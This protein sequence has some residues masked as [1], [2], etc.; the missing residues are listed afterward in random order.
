MRAAEKSPD[1]SWQSAIALAVY[2]FLPL[3]VYFGLLAAYWILPFLRARLGPRLGKTLPLTGGARVVWFHAS[4]VGEVST[5]GPVVEEVRRRW[6]GTK[7]VVSTMTVGGQRRAGEILGSVDVFLLPLDFFPLIRNVVSILRP[8]T[9]IIG[10]TEIWPN[11]VLEARKQGSHIVLLNGRIS[12][13]S[14]PRYRLV[15]PLMRTLLRRFDY[16]LMRTRSDADRI[17]DLGADSAAVEVVGNTKFDILPG[18]LAASRREATRVDMGLGGRRKVMTLGSAREGECEIVFGAMQAVDVEPSPLLIVAPRHMGLVAQVEQLAADSSLVCETRSGSRSANSGAETVPDVIIIAEM[19]RLL[20]M[21]A[22]SDIAIVGGTF[23]PFGGH[24]PLESASQGVV[25]VVGPHIQ[26]IEDD[27][28]YLR[29]RG[30]AFITDEAGLGD[31]LQKLLLDDPERIEMGRRAS[32]AVEDKKGI[33][34]KC[35]EILAQRQILP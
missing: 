7:I 2:R 33:A 30:C 19:G 1:M 34:G 9:L 31:L 26:N 25:T 21:Y 22:I 6:P 8:S 17:I 20:D 12:K 28:G 13:R 5:I 35:V 3:P 29:S 10:E 15:R 14:Y 4:S 27:I 16:L 32:A 23:K 24:N 11:L 18:P